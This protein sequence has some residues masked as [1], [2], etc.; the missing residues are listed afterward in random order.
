[1]RRVAVLTQCA[2]DVFPQ[3]GGPQ[4]MS[5]GKL[6]CAS[7]ERSTASRAS[8]WPRSWSRLDGRIRSARGFADAAGFTA[9]LDGSAL[10]AGTAAAA[11]AEDNRR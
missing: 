2:N 3:P 4:R 7:A 5:D 1:M 6:S 8:P 10:G 11:V 9:A